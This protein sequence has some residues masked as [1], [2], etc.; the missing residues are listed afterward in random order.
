M[1]MRQLIATLEQ[2]SA[3][4]GL[5]QN[6]HR[7]TGI[8]IRHKNRNRA[9]PSVHIWV[10]FKGEAWDLLPGHELNLNILKG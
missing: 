8:Q 4:H 7:V 9:T 1:T 10:Q 6:H 3:N 2:I 5:E